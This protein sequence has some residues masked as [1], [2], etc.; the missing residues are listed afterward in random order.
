MFDLPLVHV[1]V[2]L[3]AIIMVIG[4]YAYLRDTLAGLTKPN[5]VSW[6]L[7]ALAPLISVGAALESDADI[8]A[9]VRVIVGGIVPFVI[10]LSSFINRE[11]YWKLTRFDFGCGLLS[12][13]ALF[14]WSVADSPL[15]AIMLA[16]AA[17][18]FASVPTFIKAWKYPETETRLIFTTSF[19]SVAIILP[20]IPVWNIEN[21]AFQISLLVTTGLLLFAVYRKDLGFVRT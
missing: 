4:A 16:S 12:L 9:S 8:W 18:T 2:V 10:F 1:L 19:V 14:F 3:S 21:S 13:L 17:N 15:T 7:W 5:R 6:F 20:A 11:S